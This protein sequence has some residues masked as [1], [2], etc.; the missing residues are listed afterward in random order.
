MVE[1]ID[2][3][4]PPLVICPGCKASVRPTTRPLD[5]EGKKREP[6]IP[7]HNPSHKN[8]LGADPAKECPWSQRT[9]VEAKAHNEQLK[10]IRAA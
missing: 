7:A 8:P 3:V 5:G 6:I 9:V 2:T 1:T 4:E 10:K